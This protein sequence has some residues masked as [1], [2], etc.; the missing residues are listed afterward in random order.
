MRL[1]KQHTFIFLI[2]KVQ[3]QKQQGCFSEASLSSWT[4]TLS[5]LPLHMAFFL[6]SAAPVVIRKTARLNI[7][8]E[9]LHLILILS[10]M[11]FISKSSPTMR[12]WGSEPPSM[13][14]SAEGNN[15]TQNI[16]KNWKHTHKTY[17]WMFT[18]SLFTQPK[19]IVA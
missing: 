2:V 1:F 15:S 13:N 14:L 8:L 17:M 9:Q 19:V 18:A 11:T 12:N 7:W 6:C 10:S 3:A 16:Q 4:A 5:S